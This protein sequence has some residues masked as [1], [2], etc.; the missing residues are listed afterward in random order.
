M[1]KT[2]AR[3]DAVFTSDVK[4]GIRLRFNQLCTQW[5]DETSHYSAIPE[6]VLHPAYQQIIGMG[7]KALPLIFSR[8]KDKPEHWFWALKS[9]TGVDP[10]KPENRGK[11]NAMRDDWMDWAREAGYIA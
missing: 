5:V 10:V 1:K 4:P 3:H 7:E 8:L 9:I 11:I 6:I 2:I